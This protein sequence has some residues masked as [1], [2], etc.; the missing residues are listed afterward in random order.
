[1]SRSSVRNETFKNGTMTEITV[2][3]DDVLSTFRLLIKGEVDTS[4]RRMDVDCK[5]SPQRRQQILQTPFFQQ[6]TES[7]YSTF[8]IQVK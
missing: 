4:N 2:N 8:V 7:H 6:M 5:R 3:M 1:M